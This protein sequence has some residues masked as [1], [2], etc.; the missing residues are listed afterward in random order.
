MRSF[1]LAILSAMATTL[2]GCATAVATP[3]VVEAPVPEAPA[4][5]YDVVRCGV[6]DGPGRDDG[7]S[8]DVVIAADASASPLVVNALLALPVARCSG[9][10]H[11][12]DEGAWTLRLGIRSDGSVG[13]GGPSAPRHLTPF[14]RCMIEL[15]CAAP[16]LKGALAGEVD[17]RVKVA[18]PGRVRQIEVALDPEGGDVTELDARIVREGARQA[19]EACAAGASVPVGAM[20]SNLVTL[21]TSRSLASLRRESRTSTETVA[22]RD[23]E[24]ATAACLRGRLDALV[25]GDRHHS[26]GPRKVRVVVRWGEDLDRAS[27][28]RRAPLRSAP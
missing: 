25:W 9:V 15:W 17:V 19:A 18:R 22:T 2:V 1:L 14:A 11:V 10:T 23:A 7:P 20:V 16:P 4:A 6:D 28:R 12:T 8:G 3:T 21:R 5:R 24:P 13:D 27:A 26:A